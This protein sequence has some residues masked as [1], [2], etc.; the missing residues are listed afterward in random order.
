MNAL[1]SKFAL[2][3]A[4]TA[5]LALT[6][7][8]TAPYG[9]NGGYNGGYQSQQGNYGNRN[10]RCQSC[11]V[12]QEVQQVYTSGSGNGGTL[13]AIIGAVAG[14]VLGNQVGKGDGRK[15]ATVAGAVAGGVVGNQ[16]GKHNSSGDA[17]WRVVVRLDNGQYVTVTQR[18]NPGVRNGDYVEV[19][20]DHVYSR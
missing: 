17:A 6:G 3:T 7:C 10:A 12:V 18:E 11:G 13:G 20:G 19:R 16:V 9:N 8:A 14:G 1:T 2:A 15:A 4:M 5:G